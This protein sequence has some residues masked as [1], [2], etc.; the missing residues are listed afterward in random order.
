M[1]EFYGNE[2]RYNVNFTRR[3]GN[4]HES[5][6]GDR[7]FSEAGELYDQLKQ[8]AEVTHIRMSRLDGEVFEWV[9]KPMKRN[10]AGDWVSD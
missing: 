4:L 8:D 1:G 10:E 3:G 9:Q 6:Q 5:F 7:A 2:P